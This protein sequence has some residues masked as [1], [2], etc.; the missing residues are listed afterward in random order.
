VV[1]CASNLIGA[2]GIGKTRLELRVAEDVLAEV[3]DGVWFVT[4]AF[5]NEPDQVAL[6]TAHVLRLQAVEGISIEQ[7]IVYL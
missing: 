2:G 7:V 3:P 6:A 1:E 4:L 5:L